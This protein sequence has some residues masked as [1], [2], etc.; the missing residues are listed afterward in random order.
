MVDSGV[1]WTFHPLQLDV[2]SWDCQLI[3]KFDVQFSEE[4]LELFKVLLINEIIELIVVECN[5]YSA[6]IFCIHGCSS[7]NGNGYFIKYQ[8]NW[9][10]VC[11]TC[12]GK[13]YQLCMLCIKNRVCK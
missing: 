13:T 9:C 6:W 1:I 3:I 12:L 2:I 10:A 4:P 8:L 7:K 5:D 11:P